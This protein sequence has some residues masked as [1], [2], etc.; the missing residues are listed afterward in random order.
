MDYALKRHREA[1]TS[2]SN[3]SWDMTV[4]PNRWVKKVERSW[5]GPR[6]PRLR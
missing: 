6:A 1:F 3:S 5:H 4:W 2:S